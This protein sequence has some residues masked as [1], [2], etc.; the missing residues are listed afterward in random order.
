MRRQFAFLGNQR[1]Q[2]GPRNLFK[3]CHSCQ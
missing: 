3:L 2:G 1:W